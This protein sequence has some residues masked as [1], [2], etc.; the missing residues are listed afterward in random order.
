VK[1]TFSEVPPPL[2]FRIVYPCTP[3]LKGTQPGRSTGA[4]YYYFDGCTG[5]DFPVHDP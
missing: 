5:R 3:G 4:A 1:D 2:F